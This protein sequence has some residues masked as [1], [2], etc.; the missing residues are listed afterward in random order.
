MGSVIEKGYFGIDGVVMGGKD[1]FMGCFRQ[2]DVGGKY[3]IWVVK[4]GF[5]GMEKWGQGFGV[6]VWFVYGYGVYKGVLEFR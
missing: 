1:R 2:S 4:L 3:G 5:L 6:F